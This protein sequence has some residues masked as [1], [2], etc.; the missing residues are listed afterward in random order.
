MSESTELQVVGHGDM[1]VARKMPSALDMIQSVIERGVTSENVAA[2]R[3]LV[4]LKRDMDADNAAKEFAT[5]FANLQ[6]ETLRVQATRG[7]PGRDGTIRFKFAPFE[8]IMREVGPKLKAHGF[9]VTFSTDFAE[10]RLVMSCT[11]LH[12]GGHSK[13]NKFAVRVG[14]GPPNASECQADGAANTYAKRFALCNA[15]N[16]TCD[17]DTDARAEGDVITKEQATELRDRVMATGSH[18]EYFLKFAGAKTYEEIMSSKYAMLDSTLRKKERTCTQ[19][20]K[21]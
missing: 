18:E 1:A 12:I 14:S 6:G 3:E 19:T 2:L 20:Q 4:A 16:I 17:H 7:V 10:G 21:T 15:L 9:T 5:A 11:L 8:E 13:T